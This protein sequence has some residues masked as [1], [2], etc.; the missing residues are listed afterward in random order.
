MIECR[1]AC[2]Y[3]LVPTMISNDK[4]PRSQSAWHPFARGSGAT[5]GIATGLLAGLFALASR[6]PHVVTR[7]LAGAGTIVWLL[8][9][10][11]FRDPDRETHEGPGLVVSAGDGE[12][13]EIAR[14]RETTYLQ[15][16]VIRISVFLSIFDVHVQ[17]IPLHGEVA[18]VHHQPGQY[19]QA[20]RPEASAANEHIATLITT[21]YG[22]VLVKQIAG[23]MA[24][25]CVN[26]LRPGEEVR[27][28]QRFGL[29]R[30]GSRVDVLVDPSARIVVHVGDR[31]TG[32]VTPLAQLFERK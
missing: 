24:R 29:I 32:A 9:L 20:F 26:Y 1:V 10:Y 16:D 21:D 11:F 28:G 15:R 4:D 25:R 19:L 8:V 6:W 5:I 14:E 3:M 13:V 7:M 31:V 2:V 22:P 30:F 23:I 18:F 27:C 12:V 17:R